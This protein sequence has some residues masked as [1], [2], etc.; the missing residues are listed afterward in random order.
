MAGNSAPAN[1]VNWAQGPSPT[2]VSQNSFRL[3]YMS[4]VDRLNFSV[5]DNSASTLHVTLTHALGPVVFAL[6]IQPYY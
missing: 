4:T 5:N 1:W 2:P 3:Q 6:R